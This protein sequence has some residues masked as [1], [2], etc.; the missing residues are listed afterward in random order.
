MSP[1]SSVEESEPDATPTT[2]DAGVNATGTV[3]DPE[4]APVPGA[5]IDLKPLDGQQL[6]EI[7]SLRTTDANGRYQLALPPGRWEL[8]IAADGFV[9]QAVRISVPEHG[10]VEIDVTLERA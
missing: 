5:V 4:G 10:I 3:T 9:V 6:P 1:E 8:S 7:E 2:L